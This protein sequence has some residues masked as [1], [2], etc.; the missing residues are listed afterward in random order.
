MPG[1]LGVL[2]DERADL[3]LAGTRDRAFGELVAQRRGAEDP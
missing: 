2:A 3:R 1:G